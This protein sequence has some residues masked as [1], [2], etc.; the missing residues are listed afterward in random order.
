[1]KQPSSQST[2]QKNVVNKAGLKNQNPKPL[3]DINEALKKESPKPNVRQKA[4][5]RPK[6]KTETNKPS[7]IEEKPVE[8]AEPAEEDEVPWGPM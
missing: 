4:R 5:V 1:M 3:V 6:P 7:S 8:P 2:G